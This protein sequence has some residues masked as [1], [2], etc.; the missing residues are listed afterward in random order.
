MKHSYFTA[1]IL[2]GVIVIIAVGSQL[3][4]IRLYDRI[5]TNLL[6]SLVLVIG[7]QT[8]MGNSGLLS[9]A[10]IGFMGLGAYTSAVL[11]IPAQM[12]GMALPDLY[13]FMKV[14]EVSPLLAMLA[15]GVLAAVVAAI[16]AY[17]LMRLSDA[18]SV[19]TSFALLVVLYT[20]MNNWSAFTNGPR[21]LFGLPKT[22][23][24]P[25]AAIVAAIVVVVALAFK[26]SRTGKLL[27]ASREDEVAAA[28]LGADIPQLR[29]RAFILAAFIAGIGG[30]LWG[31]FITSFA[32]KA[33]Y[34]KETFLIITMLVIG[35][36]NTVTGAVAGTILVTFAYEG[37]RGTEGALNATALGAGQ[38]VGLTEIVLALAM[39]AVMIVKPGGL[40]PNREIGHILTRARR[41]KET[42]A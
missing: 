8:F 14:V 6:I 19:I 41:K 9:F 40:F 35:G 25:V 15:A 42:V 23:D 17:P 12:K 16:V 38:V 20:V 27:R 7:L 18:A 32:P 4:G 1:L 5:A 31:H 34:L 39:I 2:I 13:E 37:L 3:L 22:T 29:W 33:F 28:A 26:E 21:T 11:T 10:H 30:A 36:A 24:M